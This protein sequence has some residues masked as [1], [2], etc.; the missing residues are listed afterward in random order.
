[1]MKKLTLLIFFLF[2]AFTMA[3]AQ[4]AVKGKVT[5]NTGL[6]LPGVSVKV[7]GTLT[8]TVTDING[9]Y[10]LRAPSN[11]TLNFSFIGFASQDIATGGRSVIN[12]TLTESANNLNEVV[13]VGYG[14][15]RKAVVTG[16]VSQVG[17]ADLK[18]QQV[19]RI[20][21]ALQGRT[22]GVSVVQ[23]S[24]APG[25]APTIR[26]RGVTSINNSDPLYVI[27]GIVVLNGGIENINANDIES[28]AVLKD[29]SAAI[30]GSRA[31][32]GVILV[33]TKKGKSGAPV[34]NFNGYVGTQEPIK[35]LQLAN[36]SQYASLRNMSAANAYADAHSGSL[37]GFTAPIAT[38]ADPIGTNWQNEIFSNNAFIT[39][40]N[41][42]LSGGTDKSSYYTSLGYYD[43]QG[44][45]LKDLSDF[46]RL[47]IA[48]N[49]SYKVKKWLTIGENATYGY[50][51]STT[52]FNTNSEFG[53]PLSSAL[54]L[55]P[56]TPGIVTDQATI[57]AYN[58]RYAGKP[59]VRNSL[60]QPYGI[61]N[62]VNQEITN[63]LAFSQTILGNYNWAHNL[64][65]S[66]YVQ[67]EP[68]KGLQIKSQIGV[69]EA[70]YG[71]D[72]FTPMYY[73]NTQTNNLSN[74]PGNRSMNRNFT[75]TWDNTAAYSKA[76]GKHNFTA[77]VG[78]SAYSASSVS[79]SA[80]YNNLPITSYDQLSFNYSLPAAN[81]I[82]SSSEGQPYHTASIFGRVNYDYDEKYLLTG[83]IRR[84]GSSKFG[85][86][87]VY[88][89]FPSV[90]LGWVVTKENF[91]PK[92]SPLDF[93]K[94]RGSYGTMGNEMALS[95]FQYV[96]TIQSGKN[97][98]FGNDQL[99]IGYA[100]NT[101][102]NPDLK[103]ESTTTSNIGFDAILFNNLSVTFDLYRK[104]TKDMLRTIQIPYYAGYT[105]QPSA[106]VGNLENKGVELEL[107][108][109]KK[110][111]DFNVNLGGNISYNHNEITYLG[112]VNFYDTGSFQASAYALERNTVG[113]PVGEFFGFKE[114]GVF[115]SQ[116]EIDAYSRNGVKIQPNAK[117]G[118]FKWQDTNGDGKI[119]QTDRTFLGNPLP[120]WTYGFTFNTNYKNFDLKVFGQGVWGNKV[121][122]GYRR[123]DVQQANYPI[124]ALNAWTPSNPN[125]NYPRLTDSDPNGNFKNPSDFYLH[126]GSYFRIRTLQLGYTI[127][128]SLL[129]HADM[130][131]IRVY[132]S[133]TNLATFTSY[134][135]YDPEVAGGIDR[136]VYPPARSFLLGL[137]V[138]L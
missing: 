36:A 127:P 94:I 75:Y 104:L 1:M 120:N 33:T 4:S 97:Y 84:D 54:N 29:A 27:D 49:T 19:T 56:I 86:N 112:P 9:N 68:I 92:N 13:V 18:D 109:T 122:T 59:I 126:D 5:D 58:T 99:N 129:K 22:S 63:P 137:N 128:A 134:N 55:D 7:K 132:V 34:L 47:N 73:L 38:P 10:S 25:S 117:P 39:D 115:H 98:V 71:G 79:L 14:T 66:G 89:T 133:T 26:I 61:S 57:D 32:N 80:L 52:G 41:L 46:K 124:E 87:N 123:L 125:S 72:S 65:A 131:S 62:Y 48:V 50:I 69:K 17:P 119:D 35:K 81:R 40:D 45:I 116:A 37:A 82:A 106:N 103:W 138:T 121:F 3:M 67:I 101:P 70:F 107:N 31:S 42:S 91:F 6:P 12:V 20:D 135:G 114:L 21:Q 130:K 43:Q 113:Q 95:T 64:F 51:Q 11:A 108:Y 53:G 15:Q 23:S 24:G 110:F 30:Y 136:G 60:G 78:T 88:G 96:S 105:A 2:T 118:D 77:L 8:G 83:I 111:G 76:I 74:T 90:E 102:S 85:S 93:L 44:I 16:A 28:I 100:P